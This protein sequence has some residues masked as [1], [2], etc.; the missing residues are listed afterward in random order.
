MNF[1]SHQNMRTGPCGVVR[2]LAQGI[3]PPQV[4]F[5]ASVKTSIITIPMQHDSPMGVLF[6]PVPAI[7]VFQV[8]LRVCHWNTDLSGVLVTLQGQ[9]P[10]W[11]NLQPWPQTEDRL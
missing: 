4:T 1:T 2:Y 3:E 5:Y 8:P 6:Q 11:A 10:L 7:I 9:E